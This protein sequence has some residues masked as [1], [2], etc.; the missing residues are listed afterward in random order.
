MPG[1]CGAWV[2]DA[3]T[4]SI[5]GHVIAGDLTS[6]TAF[7]IP[8][9]KVFDD[10]EDRFGVPPL[11]PSEPAPR[12]STAV[13]KTS[14]QPSRNFTDSKLAF[15]RTSGRF[16]DAANPEYLWEKS[17]ELREKGTDR[18]KVVPKERFNEAHIDPTGQRKN[19][20]HTRPYG[21]F[22]DEPR[23]SDARFFGV[24][25][26]DITK[27]DPMMQRLALVRGYEELDVHIFTVTT[28]VLNFL[29]RIQNQ[30]SDDWREIQQRQ[31]IEPYPISGGMCALAPVDTGSSSNVVSL[32]FAMDSGL[33][34]G[35][36]DTTVTAGCMNDLSDPDILS[37]LSRG[38]FLAK[39]GNCQ[40]SNGIALTTKFHRIGT[41]DGQSSGDWREIVR[42]RDINTYISPRWSF[43]DL[44]VPGRMEAREAIEL[45]FRVL[46]F[47]DQ[48]ETNEP[49]NPLFR[50]NPLN[51][52]DH[53]E[54]TTEQEHM[55]VDLGETMDGRVFVDGMNIQLIVRVQLLSRDSTTAAGSRGGPSRG[56]HESEGH[57]S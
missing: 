54:D 27:T 6:S 17:R 19:R 15:V 23:L 3:V 45:P 25:R 9:Y 50:W 47:R 13:A 14:N 41:S 20:C 26:Q 1:D 42:L 35:D 22:I 36:Q 12:D 29:G 44:G 7:I 34:F 8:A 49:T 28:L 40:A 10:I 57:D 33:K 18:R 52:A 32:Q 53:A 2:I 24:S 48:L 38:Q 55:N 51:H 11:L 56:R 43:S 21:R 30:T 39:T 4:G 46:G 31:D 16:P 5:Y 37:G